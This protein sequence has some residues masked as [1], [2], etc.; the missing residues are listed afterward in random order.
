MKRFRFTLLAICLVLL[1]LGWIDVALFLRNPA[2]AAGRT[3][4]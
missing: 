1:Y 4:R 2:P 3:A